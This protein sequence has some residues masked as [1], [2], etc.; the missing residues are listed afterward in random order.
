MSGRRSHA[1]FAVNLAAAGSLRVFRDVHVQQANAHELVALSW[2][3]CAVGQQLSI[4]VVGDHGVLDEPVEVVESSPV[5]MD[6]GLRHRLRLRRLH[7]RPPAPT[8]ASGA[9]Q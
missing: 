4:N 2:E 6:G 3:P 8:E 1:R 5:A 7:G 9:Q